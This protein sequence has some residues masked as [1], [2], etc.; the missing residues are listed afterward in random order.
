MTNALFEM[1]NMTVMDMYESEVMEGYQ[2]KSENGAKHHRVK[3][4]R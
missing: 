3:E 2:G 4:S 1:K